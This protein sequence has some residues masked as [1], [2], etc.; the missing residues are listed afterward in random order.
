MINSST[1]PCL[2]D[3]ILN[4]ENV[5]WKVVYHRF[6][7]PFQLLDLPKIAIL[8]KPLKDRAGGGIVNM[9]T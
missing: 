1:V 9:A 5:F 4:Y 6:H 2:K 8:L 3:N 7:K